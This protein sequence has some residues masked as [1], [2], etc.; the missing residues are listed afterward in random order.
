VDQW[1][2]ELETKSSITATP[3]TASAAARLERD[4]PNTISVFEAY[5][6]TV[7]SLDFIKSERRLD[8]CPEMVVADEA[9]PAVSGGK[10]RHRRFDLLASCVRAAS[11]SLR[12]RTDVPGRPATDQAD[13]LS[14]PRMVGPVKERTSANLRWPSKLHYVTRTMSRYRPDPGHASFRLSCGSVIYDIRGSAETHVTFRLG[15]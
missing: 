1:T 6:F 3:A 12:K 8:A 5:P 2:T 15:V 9:H 14:S 10:A 13:R 11:G 7:V 4:L